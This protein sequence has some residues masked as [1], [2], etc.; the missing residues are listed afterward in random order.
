[1]RNTLFATS[2]YSVCFFTNSFFTAS[3]VL[4]SLFVAYKHVFGQGKSEIDPQKILTDNKILYILL[5]PL[6]LADDQTKIL[7]KIILMTIKEV[8][9][10]ALGGKEISIHETL[11]NIR[12]D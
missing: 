5:P 10:I 9:G 4:F 3:N 6:E 12:K 2:L 8:A 11:K 7:G 1:M